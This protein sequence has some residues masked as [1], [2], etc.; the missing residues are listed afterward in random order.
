MDTPLDSPHDSPHDST[1]ARPVARTASTRL[2]LGR[3]GEDLAADHLRACGM[4]I[5]DRNWRSRSGEV[6]IVARDGDVL[7][8][9]EVKT[10]TTAAFGHPLVAVTP[11]KLR[12]MRRLAAEWL[13]ARGL[14]VRCVRFDIVG[15]LAPRSGS[16][17]LEHVR[18]VD[19]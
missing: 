5:L 4:V 10:R 16:P 11:I 8:V 3:F 12:R 14:R 1:A 17:V 18:G 15:I 2:A 19:Q 9:C 6:D 7:V 13:A